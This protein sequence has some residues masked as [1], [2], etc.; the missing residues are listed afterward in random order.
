MSSHEAKTWHRFGRKSYGNISN[1]SGVKT[2]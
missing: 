2:L 1:S